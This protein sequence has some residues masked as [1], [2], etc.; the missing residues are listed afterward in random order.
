MTETDT[1]SRIPGSAGSIPYTGIG[2]PIRAHFGGDIDGFFGLLVDNLIQLL[3]IVVMLRTVVG[4]PG[5]TI[6]KQ[7]MPAVGASVVFGNL[8]YALQAFFGS[9]REGTHKTALPYGVNT[10]SV[11]VYILFIML[12]IYAQTKSWEAAYAAGMV[13]CIGS[14]LIEFFGAFIAKWI[15]TVTPRAALL[16]ALAG[17]A[18]TF[19]SMD[20]VVRIFS[21]PLIALIPLVILLAGYFGRAKMPFGLPA[22]L[23]ALVVGAA[24]AWILTG[25][26]NLDVPGLSWMM[27]DAANVREWSRVTESV[28]TAGWFLPDPRVVWPEIR[29]V[30]V[31]REWITYLGVIIPMGLFNL[32]GSMQNLESAE[33]AGDRYS[34]TGS[35]MVNGLGS[36]LGGLL[37]SCFPTTI[38][39]GHPGWKGMGAGWSY[40][41]MN[42]IAV[43][44][45][46]LSG[47]VTCVEAIVPISA[48]AGILLWIG[49]IILAQAF[50]ATPKKHA[51]AVGIGLFPAMAGLL[52]LIAFAPYQPGPSRIQILADD[53]KAPASEVALNADANENDDIAQSEQAE[54]S[55]TD[56]QSSPAES[57]GEQ[58][59][60]TAAA[61]V[62][63]VHLSTVQDQL[64]NEN[65]EARKLAGF[66]IHG[67]IRLE[68]G[69]LL[70]SMI[71]AAMT[72]LL[73]DQKWKQ[74]GI[75]SLVACVLTAAG[76]IHSY[77]IKGNDLYYL[78][79]GLSAPDGAMK[80]YAWEFLVAYAVIGLVLVLPGLL[81]RSASSVN[82]QNGID[83][84]A[85]A[86]RRERLRQIGVGNTGVSGGEATLP[87]RQVARSKQPGGTPESISPRVVSL[88]TQS[89]ETTAPHSSEAHKDDDRPPSEHRPI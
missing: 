36:I 48:G 2:R 14:G 5:E 6:L 87:T 57:A 32:V 21:D 19:I 71:W 12:P 70:I 75:W 26:T 45:L 18:L 15:R 62:A 31:S 81:K 72:A 46:C 43:G 60:G 86:Q 29:D 89:R 3:V 17:I 35:L 20:F 88:E 33:A 1:R 68:R 13:A 63:S 55:G 10:P 67:L 83:V 78:I 76:V 34:T 44:L 84:D 74:A 47:L 69:L 85:V 59:A 79:P 11:F 38:Y 37:G 80:S 4:V 64:M 27:H 23:V 30:F 7:V 42:G 58:A 66:S 22:G 8:F 54:I 82:L 51:G 40:S 39:I 25:L 61:V 77:A 28:Q 65:P 41:L 24:S 73:I 16:S 56:D 50:T 53:V 49:L 52:V 9:R